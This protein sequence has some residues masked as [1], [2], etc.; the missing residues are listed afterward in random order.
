MP[1]AGL[2][3]PR[4]VLAAPLATTEIYYTCAGHDPVSVGPLPLGL[5]QNCLGS[6]SFTAYS[7]DFRYDAAASINTGIN[8]A[9]NGVISA[10]ASAS[11][12][13]YSEAYYGFTGAV[14]A[15]AEGFVNFYFTQEKIKPTPWNPPRLPI[16]FEARGEGFATS[17][18]NEPQ[19]GGANFQ[20][21]AQLFLSDFPV[22]EFAIARGTSG[23]TARDSFDSSVYLWLEPNDPVLNPYYSGRLLAR[24]GVAAAATF[25]V[26]FLENGGY[27][28]HISPDTA[29]CGASVDP[30][31]RF[32]QAAFDAEYGAESFPLDEYYI[33][34]ISENVVPLP[35]AGWLM[36]T[37]FATLIGRGVRRRKA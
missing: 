27:D 25:Y 5:E 9:I 28:V 8:G 10:T 14:G 31:L 12:D 23:G 2:L 17:S 6:G 32:D 26:N 21:I 13:G 29:E 7:H 11:E 3:A 35:A 4:A 33:L 24:C 37:G 20:V 19:F 18:R 1:I 22:D 34:D 15:R 36:A 30:I 16:Y